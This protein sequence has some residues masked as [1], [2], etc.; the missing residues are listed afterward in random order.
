MLNKFKS[1]LKMSK[2]NIFQNN[3]MVQSCFVKISCKFIFTIYVLNFNISNCILNRLIK[4]LKQKKKKKLLTRKVI[5]LK[6]FILHIHLSK[7]N[8]GKS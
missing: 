2:L 1:M 7:Q 6:F 4:T 8:L 3:K 5:R